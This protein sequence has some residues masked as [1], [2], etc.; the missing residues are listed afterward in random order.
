[1][2]LTA[3]ETIDCF[4]NLSLSWGGSAIVDVDGTAAEEESGGRF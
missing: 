4:Y 3:A 1:M 2:N